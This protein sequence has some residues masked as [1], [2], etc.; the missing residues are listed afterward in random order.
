MRGPR[1]FVAITLKLSRRV[2]VAAALAIVPLVTLDA[3]VI[4]EA[5]APP[6]APTW[7]D[8]FDG[9]ALDLTRWGLSRVG[10]AL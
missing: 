7:A 1:A 5:A 4:A 6:W 3:A 8:E 10:A 2:R 9:D